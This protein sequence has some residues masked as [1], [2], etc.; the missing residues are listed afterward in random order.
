MG[1]FRGRY[2]STAAGGT[3]LQR[4]AKC[5]LLINVGTPF[6]LFRAG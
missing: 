5:V 3:L 4:D 2:L 6:V 1:R